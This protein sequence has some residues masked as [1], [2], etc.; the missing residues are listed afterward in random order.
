[1]KNKMKKMKL[2]IA[3]AWW[4]C[5][6]NAQTIKKDTVKVDSTQMEKINKMPMDSTKDNMMVVP[7]NNDTVIRHRSIDDADP[8][9]P[10]SQKNK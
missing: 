1:M 7:L 6:C 5:N 3:F 2:L 9:K 4:I 10:K 8:K